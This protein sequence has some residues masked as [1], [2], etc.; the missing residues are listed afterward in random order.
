MLCPCN[1]QGACIDQVALEDG[2]AQQYRTAEVD[3]A[4]PRN[5]RVSPGWRGADARFDDRVGEA[6][7]EPLRAEHASPMMSLQMYS[8]YSSSGTDV[9]HRERR[10]AR[11]REGL[12]RPSL[13]SIV[14][15]RWRDILIQVLG[16][17]SMY[18]S[19]FEYSNLRRV[20]R[21]LNDLP[22]LLQAIASFV[23]PGAL[24]FQR[25]KLTNRSTS[26]HA[27]V[28]FVPAGLDFTRSDAFT[29]FEDAW[30]IGAPSA[31]LSFD[32][33]AKH[34][35][36][37]DVSFTQLN[38]C[39]DDEGKDN[40]DLVASRLGSVRAAMMRA[41]TVSSTEGETP[42]SGSE[43]AVLREVVRDKL[44]QLV[45]GILECA[46]STKTWIIIDRSLSGCG[47]PS[48]EY[49]IEKAIKVYAAKAVVLV[50]DSIGRF[51]RFN[52]TDAVLSQL[53]E[54]RRMACRST[55]LDA[56]RRSLKTTGRVECNVL[57]DIDQF[58]DFTAFQAPTQPNFSL[59]QEFIWAN[60]YRQYLF[61]S[62]TH[63]VLTCGS[64]HFSIEG[65]APEVRTFA[66]GDDFTQKRLFAWMCCARPTILLSNTGGVTEIAAQMHNMIARDGINSSQAIWSKITRLVND[67][68]DRG[69]TS[70]GYPH[71][72]RMVDLGQNA[73]E[74]M[75]RSMAVIDV[76]TESSEKAVE[77][78]LYCASANFSGIPE[79]GLRDTEDAM[80]L[81]AWDCYIATHKRAEYWFQTYCFSQV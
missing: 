28:C 71:V 65:I 44:V 70:V 34:P 31:L 10:T 69:R 25:V 81:H 35:L 2:T 47:S 19:K 36:A 17:S 76:V 68:N 20:V 8:S 67:T 37:F 12:Y 74:V 39:D 33:D 63:Y 15:Q 11:A 53:N 50:L 52:E 13:R 16:A 56:Q 57:Y 21:E 55:T 48:A 40:N 30:G 23:H 54:I 18:D 66:C 3:Q 5:G 79:P 27:E 26:R 51:R 75:K 4:P 62:G 49:I 58:D 14:L 22:H 77:V 60:H 64:S 1:P 29:M 78:L 32:F 7:Q 6:V 45:G 38:D 61:G 9:S 43:R 46:E 24:Q 41:S 59:P 73:L 42:G 80:L 72:M